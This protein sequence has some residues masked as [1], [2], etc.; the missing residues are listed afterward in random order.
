MSI[1]IGGLHRHF[2]GQRSV[3]V[4]MLGVDI[5]DELMKPGIVDKVLAEFC[6]EHRFEEDPKRFATALRVFG[7]RSP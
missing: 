7:C 5:V 2:V 3:S 4:L 1:T 6:K